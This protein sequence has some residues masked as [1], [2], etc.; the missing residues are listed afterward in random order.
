MAV[1]DHTRVNDLVWKWETITGNDTG[2]PLYMGQAL[3]IIMT[4]QC[5]GTFGDTVTFQISNDGTNWSTAEDVNGNA[6]TFTAADMFEISTAAQY[7]R[8]SAGAS[9]TDVDFIVSFG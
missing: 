3:G 6:V 9:I 1:I 8:P 5:V 7:C 4:V 2:A